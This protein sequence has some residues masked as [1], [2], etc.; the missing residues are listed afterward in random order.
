METINYKDEVLKV[1]PNAVAYIPQFF[2]TTV[3]EDKDTGKQLG[4]G[5]FHE[6][7]WQNA[8]NTHIKNQNK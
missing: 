8:Y 4:K 1:Y 2:D 5:Y 6:E 7:A 3:V